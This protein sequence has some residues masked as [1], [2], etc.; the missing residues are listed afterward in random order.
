MKR[1]LFIIVA[2]IC[3]MTVNAQIKFLETNEPTP[4]T[5]SA[6][7]STTSS[8]NPYDS[9]TNTPLTAEEYIRLTGQKVTIAPKYKEWQST[10]YKGFGIYTKCYKDHARWETYAPSID[11]PDKSDYNSLAKREFIIVNTEV[12]PDYVYLTIANNNDTLVYKQM[13]TNS[14]AFPFIINGYLE[15]MNRVMKNKKYYC[16]ATSVYAQTIPEDSLIYIKKN[17]RIVIEGMIIGY[18]EAVDDAIRVILK[19]TNGNR[20][21]MQYSRFHGNFIAAAEQQKRIAEQQ[22]RIAEL[23]SKYGTKYVDLAL[24]R[25]ICVGMPVELLKMAWGRP[26]RINDS[27][28]GDEQWC[29]GDGYYV[30]VG[31]SGTIT[32]WQ[33]RK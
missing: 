23:K 2:L 8:L 25:K 11:S 31:K 27:S 3:T 26:E 28:Y 22:K 24:Q 12:E 17:E 21:Q 9:L 5:N 7:R 6:T 15:K 29:Y 13:R 1:L 4:R 30:Y 14:S 33:A 10:F 20:V 19:R 16:S 32:A 18:D